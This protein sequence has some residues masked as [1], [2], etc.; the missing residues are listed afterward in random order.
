MDPNCE[1]RCLL[2]ADT[3]C[4]GPEVLRTSL[5]PEQLH[6]GQLFLRGTGAAISSRASIHKSSCPRG[7]SS[8]PSRRQ[9]VSDGI[10]QEEED[11][12]AGVGRSR[13]PVRQHQQYSD[14]EDDYDDDEE[15]EV[16]NTNSAIR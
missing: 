13:V 7:S 8:S 1:L 16:R 10:L 11:L 15:E 6:G 4:P 2:A 3:A 5:W 14:D 9:A 12:A